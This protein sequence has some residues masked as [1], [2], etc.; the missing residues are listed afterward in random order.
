MPGH[1]Y[2]NEVEM[3][4]ASIRALYSR[5]W[6]DAEQTRLA[7]EL[8]LVALLYPEA[9]TIEE[10]AS[11]GTPEAHAFDHLQ[12]GLQDAI[13]GICVE[14]KGLEQFEKEQ[15]WPARSAKVMLRAG[16]DAYEELASEA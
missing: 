8:A 10:F 5:G 15:G 7:E 11:L 16:L 12:P 13:F 14:G 1:K 2:R 4:T 9:R 6:L 3:Q